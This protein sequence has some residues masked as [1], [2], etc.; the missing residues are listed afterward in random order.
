MVV[1]DDVR[2]R[3]LINLFNLWVPE[4]RQRGDID[5][6]L[7]LDDGTELPFE[8]KSTTGGSISTVRDFGPEHIRK[9]RGMHWVFGFYDETGSRLRHCHYGSPQDMEPWIRQKEEYI[10]P[11]I[12]LAEI[13]QEAVDESVLDRIFG[14]RESFSLEDARRIHKKQLRVDEYRELMDLEDGYSRERMLEIL[15]RRAHYVVSRGATLNNPH[16][17]KSYFEGWERITHNH[18]AR[19]RELVT[20]ALQERDQAKTDADGDG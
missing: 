19:L 16:I 13:A 14:R 9:W 3:E 7:S 5:A 10:R 6:R 17:P 11:D 18:A 20:E 2:E 12:V 1:Q 4:E 8:V 15:G